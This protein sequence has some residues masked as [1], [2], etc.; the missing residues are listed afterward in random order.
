MK[1]RRFVQRERE[2]GFSDLG[3]RVSWGGVGGVMGGGGGEDAVTLRYGQRV[4]T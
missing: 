3:G 4:G 2:G 1:N